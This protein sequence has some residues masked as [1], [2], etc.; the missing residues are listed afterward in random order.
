MDM[1][2]TGGGA[3]DVQYYDAAILVPG[4]TVPMFEEKECVATSCTFP[5]PFA[6][7]EPV[8]FLFFVWTPWA[9]AD[10]ANHNLLGIGGHGAADSIRLLKANTN[11]LLFDVY[12]NAAAVKRCSTAAGWAA[13]SFNRIACS[14]SSAGVT[15]AALNGT[16]FT[17]RND[18]AGTGLE[19]ALEASVYF[20]ATSAGAFPLNGLILP[21]IYGGVAWGDEEC[22]RMSQLGAPPPRTR[23][24]A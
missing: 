1:M 22:Q 11:A 13:G 18:G 19:A 24:V 2:S 5:T 23:R 9:G 21:F 3:G 8:S 12:D 15:T 20:G 7:G 10:G 17:T 14:R 4:A 6:A 16:L